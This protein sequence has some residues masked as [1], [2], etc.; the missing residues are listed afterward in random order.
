MARAL[1]EEVEATNADPDALDEILDR[2]NYRLAFWRA[3]G[4]DLGY[5]RFFD[6]TSLIGMRVEDPVVFEDTHAL[7]LRWLRD[8]VIDGL[9]VD[10]PDGLRD[11]ADYFRALRA[12]APRAWIV[13]EKILEGEETLPPTGPSTGRPAT[14]S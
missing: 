6:V 7:V 2:Q 10:H 8:G 11:P 9:R 13:A 1:D 3:A 4:R 14:S 12:A 5:R